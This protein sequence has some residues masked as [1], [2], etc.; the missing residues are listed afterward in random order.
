MEEQIEIID[1]SGD[2]K[3]FSQLPTYVLNHSTA[4]EHSL[5]WIMLRFAGE[6]GR[7]FASKKTM[8]KMM[9]VG[10][11]SF[12]KSLNYLLDKK[13][14]KLDGKTE[15][16]TRGGYQAVNSYRI[17]DIWKLNV[18]FYENKGGSETAPL[19]TKG[20]LKQPKGGSE[21]APNNNH[22]NNNHIIY[23]E[24]SSQIKEVMD[25]FYKI[26]PT[27]NWGNKTIRKSC[28]DLIKRF[29]L[30][31]TIKM[32]KMIVEIQ[33]QPYAPVATTPYQMKEKLAQFK[34]YFDK[35]KNKKNEFKI[36]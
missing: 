24:Q 10:K 25:I 8:R 32:A 15:T 9:G 1:E 22:I 2:K 4:N 16:K 33:G 17:V 29:G 3:Y 12:E 26:N 23:S 30:E 34:I 19:E 27:L 36:L 6:N 31:G 18:D 14:I 35:E 28:Q 21:T 11:T 5:Y 7:C 13:W 20:G